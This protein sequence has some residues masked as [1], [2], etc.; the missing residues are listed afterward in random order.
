MFVMVARRARFYA[1]RRCRALQ[2]DGEIRWQNV[3]FAF[4]FPFIMFCP[5]VGFIRVILN[6]AAY[7]EIEMM[8][9]VVLTV[10][11]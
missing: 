3:Y 7:F 5:F 9:F 1:Y 8:A 10:R 2:V 11:D 6:S 4:G